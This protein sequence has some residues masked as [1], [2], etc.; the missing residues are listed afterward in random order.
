MSEGGIVA[1]V[2][3]SKTGQ[4]LKDVS[5]GESQAPRCAAFVVKHVDIDGYPRSPGSSPTRPRGSS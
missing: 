2:T 5:A 4:D 1:T 3:V